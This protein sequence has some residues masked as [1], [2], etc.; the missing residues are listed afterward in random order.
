VPH[1]TT[2]AI[3]GGLSI[4][5][6][7]AGIGL[8]RSTIAEI[9][10]AYLQDPEVPYYSDLVPGTRP[11]ADWAQ[12]QAQEYQAAAQA[13][14]PASCVGCTWPV[15]PAPREDP[16][17]ARY[18]RPVT[19]ALPPSE[20]AEAPARIVIVEPPASP[21]RVRIVRYASYPVSRDEPPPPPPQEETDEGDGG[22]Q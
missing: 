15:D 22:T 10:P 2:L 4:A 19:A 13:P 18:D 14:P 7:A 20:R 1:A 12:V 21:E 17:V 8:G 11:R 16:V 9:N 6:A 5:A 3:A